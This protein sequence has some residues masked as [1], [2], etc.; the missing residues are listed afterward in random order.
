VRRTVRVYETMTVRRGVST[1]LTGLDQ[2]CVADITHVHLAEGI[3]YLTVILDAFSRK[4]SAR[5]SKRICAELAIYA[6]TARLVAAQYRAV[7]GPTS[8]IVPQIAVA[9][10]S[11]SEGTTESRPAQEGNRQMQVDWHMV[12]AVLLC[13]CSDSIRI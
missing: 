12:G 9:R 13:S 3:G 10:Y 4:L 2:V 8:R 7:S 11:G 5:R 6:I 1:V